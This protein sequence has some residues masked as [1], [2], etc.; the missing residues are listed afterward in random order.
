MTPKQQELATHIDDGKDI[1]EYKGTDWKTLEGLELFKFC[2]ANKSFG[3][4]GLSAEEVVVLDEVMKKLDGRPLTI[5][6]T[7]MCFGVTTRYFII[8]NI[9]FG[10]ELNTFEIQVRPKFQVAMEELGLWDKINVLGHSMTTPWDKRINLLFIDSEHAFSDALGEYM[11]FRVYLDG[12]S[13]VGFHDSD[14]CWGVRRAIEIANEIDELELIGE[15]TGRMSAGIKFFKVKGLGEKQ[16]K[17]NKQVQ[18]EERRKIQ[19]SQ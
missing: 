14:S 15:V 18:D 10:G 7:G 2:K 8:R 5:V 1:L 13:I 17:L 11:R 19:E 4:P 12:D 6:E 3:E 16:A 9:K